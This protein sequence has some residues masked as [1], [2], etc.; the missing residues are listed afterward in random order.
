[1]NI[2]N[3]LKHIVFKLPDTFIHIVY[4]LYNYIYYFKYRET[5]KHFGTLNPNIN[6]YVIRP[7]PNSV[8]GLMSIFMETIK[9]INYS[10][11]KGYIP[12]IDFQNYTTQYND[13][14]QKEKN[15]WEYYFKQ[16]SNYKLDEVY[17]SKNVYLSG[18]NSI[19]LC[20]K[21]FNQ[22]FDKQSME[23]VR[24]IVKRYIVCNDNVNYFVNTQLNEM[25]IDID[26]TIGL[27]LRGTDYT[28]LKPA[29]H[30]K[31]PTIKEALNQTDIMLDKTK[32]S[33]IFLVTEDIEIYKQV[34]NHYG[35]KLKSITKDK[36]ISNYSG[37]DFLINDK[38]S[39]N[40]LS[41]SPYERGLIY[42]SK[43]LIL[44]KCSAIVAGNTSGSWGAFALSNGF[45]YEYV[46]NL[47]KY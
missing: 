41:I 7:R 2:K 33:N 1:M 38:D 44:S 20:P 28:K 34:K 35:S 19:E 6:F 18:L 30:Q 27:Y 36:F 31:Q 25:N 21:E 15:V 32:Y 47:G 4:A 12:I 11:E 17:K 46:F 45:K 39:I 24:S 37:K 42:L 40:Q 23:K 13:L 22:N 3:Y 14:N 10:I 26:K 16:I 5:K 9:Q 43:I 29:G 8:Q